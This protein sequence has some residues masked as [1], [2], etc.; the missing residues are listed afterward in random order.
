MEGCRVLT[1]VT[2]FTKE[3]EMEYARL[4][5]GNT[6]IIVVDQDDPKRRAQMKKGYTTFNAYHFNVRA[7]RSR[8]FATATQLK[9]SR[10]HSAGEIGFWIETNQEDGGASFG[11]NRED[12]I[13]L[14]EELQRLV[15]DIK[16]L[17]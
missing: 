7:K 12:A 4:T 10:T 6:T 8:G 15:N 9:V 14:S 17:R 5:D 3:N 16:N 1:V 2:Q 13:K 11:L